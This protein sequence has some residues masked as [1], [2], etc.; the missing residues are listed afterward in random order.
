MK[1]ENEKVFT[2]VENEI[3]IE[4]EYNLLNK[5]QK[6]FCKKEG[7]IMKKIEN[8]KKFKKLLEKICEDLNVQ[9][10]KEEIE[11]FMKKQQ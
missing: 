8:V 10:S 11:N 4:K 7:V 1:K 5:I 2:K 3:I 6:K 9:N